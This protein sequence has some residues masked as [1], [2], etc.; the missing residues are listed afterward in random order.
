MSSSSLDRRHFLSLL[1][2][3]GA[4][5]ALD[6][7]PLAHGIMHPAAK[8]EDF[9]FIFFTDTH[10][11]PELNGAKGCDMAFKKMS[12]IKADFAIQGGDH[13]FDAL[14]APKSRS[15]SLFELYDKTQQ[16]LSLKVYHTLGN[17]DCLGIYKASGVEPN[18]PLYGKKYYE[19]HVGKT[20]YSFDRKG[21]HFIILDSIGITPDRAYE[22]RIDAAQ[23][24]WLAEDLK[25]QFAGTPIIVVSHIP[26]VTAFA[27]YVPVSAT[28]EAH[29]GLSVINS[30]EVVRMFDGHNVLAVLQ[31]H[32]HIN[33]RVEWH[34]VPYITSGAV[35][36][37]W[38]KGTRMGTPE[39]FTVVSVRDGKLCTRY[40]TYGFHTVDPH[41]T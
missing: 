7:S 16:D 14:G 36:G 18:D 11:Q 5:T 39:G 30:D 38:W 25:A 9:D 24:Q 41:N 12:G 13:V 35:S 31:G 2:S 15:L 1:G 27:S 8:A 17:H 40:E 10:L 21:V 6:G 26:L 32:T 37:N 22:G 23:V 33:E 20:F 19:E 28:P 29:H 34:G 4:I 3:A